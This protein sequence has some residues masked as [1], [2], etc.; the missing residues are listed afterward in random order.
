[1][2][3]RIGFTVLMLAAAACADEGMWLFNEFPKQAV[4]KKY[5]FKVTD[6]F[7]DHLRLASVR[8]NNGGSGSFIS[9]DG[10]LF[11]NHH[12]G[13]DCIQKI[14]SAEHDYMANGFYAAAQAEERPC[15]D[16]EVNVLLKI[17]DVTTK[18]TSGIPAGTPSAEANQRRKTA[19][20]AIEKECTSSTGNRCDVVTLYSGGEYNLYQYKK[21]TDIL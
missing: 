16:L 19:M 21:Y 10:L 15:P 5:H 6:A 18:V 17:E 14:S 12:V 11:T 3:R 8:F 7:L 4:E 13:S 9:P 1:M 2:V 20:S